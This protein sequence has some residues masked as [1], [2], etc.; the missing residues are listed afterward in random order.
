MN[1]LEPYFNGWRAVDIDTAAVQGYIRTR[2]KEGAKGGTINRELAALRRA[3]RLGQRVRMVDHLPTFEML[4]ENVREGFIT[5]D[6]FGSLL[7]ELPDYLRPLVEF[8]YVTGWRVGDALSRTWKDVDL[9]DPGWVRI[10]G[11]D[12]KEK[13]GRQFPMIPRLRSVLEA[14]QD[15]REDFEA[16]L[17]RK[18]PH[19]FFYYRTQGAARAGAPLGDCRHAWR[20]ACERAE[21]V[22][23]GLY[24]HD[25]RRSAAR[26]FIRA[27]MSERNAMALTGH[28]TPSILRRY[29]IVS[30]SDLLESGEKLSAF[31][32]AGAK[33]GKR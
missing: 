23:E 3:M 12:T 25:L 14:Q 2:E 24:I 32:D 28:Q 20:S 9:G 13:R 1:H 30:E 21:G 7:T 19:V 29:D 11:S 17:G 22:P 4:P 33:H 26:S 27:G 5:E 15:K 6:Q 18:I 8:L 16:K 31:F 10:E